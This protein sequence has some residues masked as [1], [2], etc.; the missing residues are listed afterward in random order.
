MIEKPC[1][2]GSGVSKAHS[3]R[4][5]LFEAQHAAAVLLRINIWKRGRRSTFVQQCAGLARAIR[6]E[7]Q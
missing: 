7:F 1:R 2:I 4:H 3:V 5:G 6:F